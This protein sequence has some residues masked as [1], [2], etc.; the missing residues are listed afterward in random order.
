MAELCS[1]CT[2]NEVSVKCE[3][4]GAPLCGICVKEVMLQEMTP[5]SMVKPGIS[6]SPTRPGMT[7]KKVCPKCMKEADLM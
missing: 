2:K 3:E 6:M 4:C 1:V 5:A 7:K